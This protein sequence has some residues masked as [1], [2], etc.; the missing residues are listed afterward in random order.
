MKKF[1]IFLMVF[2]VTFSTFF[3]SN[4]SAASFPDVK[5]NKEEIGYLADK[6]YISGYP[7]G[8]FRPATELTRLQGIRVL[9]KAKGVTDL[10]APNPKFTDMSPSSNGYA[11][12]AKAVQLG[13]ISGKIKKDGSKY[14]DPAGKLTRGQM[15]KIIVETM[16]YKI[17][18]SF[19]FR[20]L[21]KS[22]GY[23]NY[24][25]TLAAERITEGYEDRT[26]KPN[27]TVTRQHFAVFV[28]RMLDEKFKTESMQKSYL[29]DK[30]MDYAWEYIVNGKTHKS[31]GKYI[32]PQYGGTGVWD[33][34][35]ETGTL[36]SGTFTVRE[37]KDKLYT[38]IGNHYYVDLEYPLYAGK[39]FGDPNDGIDWETYRVI[40]VNQVVK[41]K[42]GTFVDVVE[43]KSSEGWTQY[44]APNVGRIKSLDNGKLYSELVKLTPRR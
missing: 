14:F 13:I 33:L 16:N 10:T 5:K 1:G 8:N 31:T 29:M 40:A 6:G 32:G 37:S 7:D 42:A 38:G 28:A 21:P 18:T 41:T 26:F 19:S 11:E 2:I 15:A 25:S 39:R 27:N 35:N 43:I 17:N 30:T 36:E 22:S 34:W 9:L 12:V 23:F 3:S 24:V 20:D 44:Y 4:A